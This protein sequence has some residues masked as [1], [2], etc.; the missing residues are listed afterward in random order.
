MI[1]W[2]V[3]AGAGDTAHEGR[4]METSYAGC[5]TGVGK[6]TEIWAPPAAA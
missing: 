3:A 2:D 1:R 6:D 4:S 5:R